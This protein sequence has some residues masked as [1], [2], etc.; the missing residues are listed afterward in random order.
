MTPAGWWALALILF[1]SAVV[2]LVFFTGLYAS[3]D[4]SYLRAAERLLNGGFRSNPALGEM[5]L[6]MVGWNALV[7]TLTGGNIQLVAASYII[8]HQLLNACA[9]ALGARLFRS[10]VGLLAAYLS[11][12]VP[13]HVIS[14]TM[15]LPDLQMALWMGASLLA[16]QEACR[17]RTRDAAGTARV[18]LLLAGACVGLAYMTKESG[19]VAL[20]FYLGFW[21]VSEFQHARKRGRAFP[22]WNAI[23]HGACFAIGF[24]V[25]FVGESVALSILTG[26]PFMRLGWTV[27]TIAPSRIERVQEIGFDPLVR[28]QRV[29]AI[30]REGDFMPTTL[31]GLVV[32]GLVGFPLL[33]RRAWSL[34]LFPVWV[35]AYLTW[36]S[37]S[38]TQY[39]P[40]YIKTRYYIPLLPFLLIIACAVLWRLGS[41][42]G[43]RVPHNRARRV[44]AGLAMTA[45][46]VLPLHWLAIPNRLA[47]NSYRANLV[48]VA[49]QAVNTALAQSDRPVVLSSGVSRSL[50]L[51][52]E[53]ETSSRVILAHRLTRP[54]LEQIAE[55]GGCEYVEFAGTKMLHRPRFLGAPAPLDR[56]VYTVTREPCLPFGGKTLWGD[57]LLGWSPDPDCAPFFQLGHHR[58]TIHPGASIRSPKSRL[59]QLRAAILGEIIEPVEGG[60][61]S[62]VVY[63]L[64][65]RTI[66][67]KLGKPPARGEV[68]DLGAAIGE[69]RVLLR[70]AFTSIETMDGWPVVSVDLPRKAHAV[71]ALPRKYAQSRR[72]LTAGK[73]WEVVTWVRLDDGVQLDLILAFYRDRGL[74]HPAGNKTIRMS[75]GLNRFG[76]WPGSRSLYVRPAF[77]VRGRG[78]FAVESL[79]LL[80]QE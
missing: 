31:T 36:G 52:L 4:L 13:V 25:I 35:F 16:F 29:T 19:L 57:A 73:C 79:A 7:S 48:R 10:G 62:A 21:L 64:D 66:S 65:A 18:L 58:F 59:A 38:L 45:I 46:V 54:M 50:A 2:D 17:C 8:W 27:E 51:L 77:Y 60:G 12:L 1:A 71:Y 40:P 69:W 55:G 15:V 67:P 6:T 11:A 68:H 41:L 22:S 9:F 5:R 53:S 26:G 23:S 74:R 47:G 34:Y 30:L 33:I 76:I 3:D 78:S 56:L 14:S 24:F 70:E 43:G 61:R 44:L 42:V 80:A 49:A 20:P 37:M 72:K 75:N 63:H 32:C 39:V 28:W